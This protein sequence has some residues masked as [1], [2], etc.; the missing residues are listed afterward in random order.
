MR[1]HERIQCLENRP[2]G[3]GRGEL[4]IHQ[5][6]GAVRRVERS[7]RPTQHATDAVDQAPIGENE[8]VRGEVERVGRII[9]R[10]CRT[11]DGDVIHSRHW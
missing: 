9:P 5:R 11:D 3:K 6:A 4:A 2:A 1:S 10:C 7:R 8:A